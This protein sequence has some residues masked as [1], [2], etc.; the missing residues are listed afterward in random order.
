M[1][2]KRSL[3]IQTDHVGENKPP[4]IMTATTMGTVNLKRDYRGQNYYFSF[5]YMIK[6]I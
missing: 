3:E 6:I 4:T 1:H 5:V 2:H